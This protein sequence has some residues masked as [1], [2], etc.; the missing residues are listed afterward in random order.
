MIKSI[1]LQII[2][3]AW[4]DIHIYHAK[5]PQTTHFCVLFYL[6]MYI[7]LFYYSSWLGVSFF[8]LTANHLSF[9]NSVYI[10]GIRIHIRY[11]YHV[12][13][14]TFYRKCLPIYPPA[15]YCSGG[16]RNR[17]P[18]AWSHVRFIYDTKYVFVVV[19]CYSW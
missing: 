4:N 10:H 7:L 15:R 14:L 2:P 1:F 17:L 8:F 13:V 9:R 6:N 5:R 16:R 12:G 3:F 18:I 19:R 11:P